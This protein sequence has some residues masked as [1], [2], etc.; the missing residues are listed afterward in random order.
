MEIT[1]PICERTER[2]LDE[3]MTP[4]QS[5]AGEIRLLIHWADDECKKTWDVVEP[6][7]L[8]FELCI[9]TASDEN[10]EELRRVGRELHTRLQALRKAVRKQ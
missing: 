4:L 5:M 10:A 3:L 9:E 1:Q 6:N 2:Y 8:D 7:L